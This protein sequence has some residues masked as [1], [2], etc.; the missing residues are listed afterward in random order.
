MKKKNKDIDDMTIEEMESDPGFQDFMNNLDKANIC[1]TCDHC[2][3]IGEGDSICDA[4][5]PRIILA[6]W[7]PT[8]DYWYCAGC[9]YECDEEEDDED[10]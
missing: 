5:E 3:Y 10:V 1:L 2:V 9:D 6:D 7:E 8:D 4:N